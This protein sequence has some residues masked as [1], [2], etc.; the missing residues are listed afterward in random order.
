MDDT[1][2]GVGSPVHVRDLLVTPRQWTLW[3]QRPRLVVFCLVVE[4][5]AV[6]TTVL[7]AGWVQPGLRDGLVTLALAA[8]GVT[9]AELGRQVERVR[10]RVNGTPHINMTSVWTF[11]GVLLL[12]PAMVAVLVAILYAHLALRS[13]YRLQRVPAFRSVINGSVV[14]LTCYTARLVLALFGVDG[15]GDALARGWLGVG[16]I[17]ATVAAYFVANALLILGALNMTNHSVRELFGG[18]ADNLVELATLCLGTLTAL[19]VATQP[20]LV[21]MVVPPLLVLHRGVLVKQLEVAA[22]KDEKTGLFNTLG[23]HNLATNELARAERTHQ[24]TGVLMVDLDH[25]KQ[26]NDTY[27]HL[28]GD[29]ALKAVADT[30]TA[31][32]R[33]YDSVGRFGGEEFVVLLPG[34]GQTQVVAV[35]ER[36]RRAVGEL[37]VPIDFTD[38]GRVIRDLSVSI[39][40]AMYPTAGTVVDRLLHAA[41]TALYSAKNT[42][43]NRVVSF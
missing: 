32:V 14:V 18:W 2:P 22:T 21:V 33:S 9:Q 36:I 10:R 17:T 15:I 1:R 40:V 42:G 12:P 23:W 8:L 19:A 31:Q 26:V 25:F 38:D 41:D 7:A 35:A 29:L 4:A 34:V 20:L 24:T 37:T 11:A 3:R 27:G 13:W 43:R 28:A 6:A 30:I 39:G 16:A 5:V